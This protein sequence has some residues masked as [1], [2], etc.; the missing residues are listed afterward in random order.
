M[1]KSKTKIKNKYDVDKN[2]RK[3]A[4]KEIAKKAESII[5]NANLDLSDFQINKVI[6]NNKNVILEFAQKGDKALIE[7]IRSGKLRNAIDRMK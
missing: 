7:E 1:K 2:L 6:N 4:E 5:R 3:L